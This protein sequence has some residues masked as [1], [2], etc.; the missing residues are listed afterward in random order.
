MFW[1]P[2]I[3][4]NKRGYPDDMFLISQQ[5]HIL[6]VLVKWLTGVDPDGF[7]KG[8]DIIILPYLLYVFGQTVLSKQC[9]PRSDAAFCG[10]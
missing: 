10:I 2:S 6:W 8:F 9:R 1:D 3:A 4:Q 7:L 5:K